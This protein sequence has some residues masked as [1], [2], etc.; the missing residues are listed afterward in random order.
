MTKALLKKQLLE[1]FSWLYIDRK[2]GKNRSRNGIIGYAVLYLI[3]FVF[4]GYLPVI[5]SWKCA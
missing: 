1:V 4:L 2:S 3:V 5:F